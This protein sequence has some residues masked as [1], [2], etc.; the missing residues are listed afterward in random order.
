MNHSTYHRGQLVN[1]LRQ[2]GFTQLSSTDLATYYRVT[3]QKQ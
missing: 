3:G 2:V 1:M